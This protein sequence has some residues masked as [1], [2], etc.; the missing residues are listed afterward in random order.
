R[1]PD[2]GDVATAIGFA[3]PRP[4]H[5]L[6]QI[7]QP[8]GVLIGGHV[9]EVGRGL[10]GTRL[11]SLGP[12]ERDEA[13]V[14]ARLL[15]ALDRRDRG[16]VDAAAPGALGKPGHLA[17][18]A[19]RLRDMRL[20]GLRELVAEASAPA[21]VGKALDAGAGD[22]AWYRA[23]DGW[24]RPRTLPE[25]LAEL[26]RRPLGREDV[27]LDARGHLEARPDSDARRDV[28]VPMERLGSARRGDRPGVE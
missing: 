5:L 24:H 19:A 9:R 28:E 16:D 25:R 4:D 1:A 18:R 12:D 27:E 23:A 8:I 17:G 2:E 3:P 26:G 10:E 6:V 13:E 15:G 21:A 14:L 11:A 7:D 22:K 20:A